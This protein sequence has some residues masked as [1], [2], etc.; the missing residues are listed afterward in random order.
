MSATR[1]RGC[2]G[3]KS[4]LMRS[5]RPCCARS[6]RTRVRQCVGRMTPKEQSVL[7]SWQSRQSAPSEIP[8]SPTTLEPTSRCPLA[9]SEPSRGH[10]CSACRPARRRLASRSWSSK[11]SCSRPFSRTLQGTRPRQSHCWRSVCKFRSKGKTIGTFR[12]RGVG[13]IY[14]PV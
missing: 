11:H 1:S 10:P 14:S 6:S 13:S 3:S 4:T 12:F 7:R 2:M 8:I 5:T 9:S